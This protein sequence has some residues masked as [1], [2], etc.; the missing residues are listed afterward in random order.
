MFLNSEKYHTKPLCFN[1][2]MAKYG[3]LKVYLIFRNAQ[4][5]P[6]SLP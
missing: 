3:M 2:E 1:K 6:L 5:T 4:S